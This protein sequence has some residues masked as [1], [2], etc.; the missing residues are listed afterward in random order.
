LVDDVADTNKNWSGFKGQGPNVKVD[1][2]RD[3]LNFG[4]SWLLN[5]WTD[6]DKNIT[7]TDVNIFYFNVR[8]TRSIFEVV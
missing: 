4:T 5:G 1:A 3:L 6:F 8:F 7:E 2:T